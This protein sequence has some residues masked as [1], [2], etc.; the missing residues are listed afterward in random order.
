MLRLDLGLGHRDAITPPATAS[1]VAAACPV[2]GRA[3]RGL[4]LARSLAPRGAV[5]RLPA[6]V[7]ATRRLRGRTPVLRDRFGD[8]E[9]VEPVVGDGVVLRLAPRA[10]EP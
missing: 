10:T 3:A 7:P 9:P 6:R 5:R 1:P 8:A 4:L 2:A